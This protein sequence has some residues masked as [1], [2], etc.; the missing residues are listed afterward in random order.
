MQSRY[1]WLV[2]VLGCGGGDSAVDKCNTLIGVTC[3]RAVECVPSIGTR[4]DCIRQVNASLSCGA[5][6]SVKATFDSCLSLM[7]TDSCSTLFP[8]DPQT[9]M[10]SLMLPSDC[11]GVIVTQRI[12]ID[13]TH[14]LSELSESALEIVEQE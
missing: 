11:S 2:F 10:P 1:L 6:K 7:R 9:G 8:P 3:D 5:A 12:A 14:P 4:P 13:Q